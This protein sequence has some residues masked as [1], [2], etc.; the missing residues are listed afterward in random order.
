[1]VPPTETR[2]FSGLRAAHTH[3]RIARLAL[4]LLLLMT[5]AAASRPAGTAPEL[6]LMDIVAGDYLLAESVS[7]Y[8]SDDRWFV[9]FS[10][11]LSAV[12]FPIRRSERTWTGWFRRE[13]NRFEWNM[14]EADAHSFLENPDGTFVAVDLLS[15]WFGVELTADPRSQ[16]IV[17]TSDEPLPFQQ[18]LA[19]EAAKRRH[20]PAEHDDFDVAIPDQYRWAT[21]PL[22]DVASSYR[23]Q[24]SDGTKSSSSQTSL[25][26]GMDL[27]KHSVRYS[28]SSGDG[29]EQSRLT[30]ERRALVDGDRIG[31]G[32]DQ[33]AFGDVVETGANLVNSGG[34]GKGFIIERQPSS[35]AGAQGRVTITGEG[36]PGWDV[37]LYRNESLITFGTVEPD[38]RFVF[39]DQ[40]TVYGE[41]IFL[42]KLFGPQGEVREQRQ[43]LWGG[44]IQLEPGDYSFHVSRIDFTEDFLDGEREGI[45]SLPAEETT[46]LHLARAVAK[47]LQLGAGY[48]QARVAS[49]DRDGTFS[50]SDYVTLD[51][52]MNIAEG[53]LLGELVDQRQRGSAWSLTW[54]TGF[55]GNNVALSHQ[56]FDDFESPYT[57]GRADLD[58]LS[59][60][61]LSGPLEIAGLH[62]YTL[63]LS[64]QQRSDG[65]VDLRV[66]NR[67]GAQWG[68]INVANDLDV[69]RVGNGDQLVQGS[70]RLTGRWNRLSLRGQLDYDPTIA[71]LLNQVS[72]TLS[73]NAARD[74]YY[75]LSAHRNMRNDRL[76][77]VENT[78]TARVGRVD[79]SFSLQTSSDDFWAVGL[80]VGTSFGADE[81]RSSFAGLAHTG[82]ATLN[83]F[84]DSNNN[85]VR[86]PGEA[87][88]PWA[89][90]GE[91]PAPESA[92]GR[93]RLEAVPSNLPIQIDSSDFRF[94]DPFLVARDESYEL[95]THPGSDVTAN[96]PVINTADVEG[97]LYPVPGRESSVRG[98]SVV[99]Y[100]AAGN[101]VA[102]TRSEFDGY[103]SF[104]GIPVGDYE[105]VVNASANRA[106]VHN[107]WFSLE[108]T[109]G[110]IS[111]AP[112]FIYWN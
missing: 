66:F 61:T 82:R 76:L 46:T 8:R 6:Y 69:L 37:E 57:V 111:L 31:L 107:Q 74:L 14:D 103:Y 21:V 58:A 11:F 56:A 75:A 63:R 71:P 17:L 40:E 51:G 47:E 3:G 68:P 90:Y 36:P 83:F 16:V 99:L 85:G 2:D 28:G 89:S 12:E 13:S 62:A 33:Y 106:E 110:F 44:G 59:E 10:S 73:W 104:H 80:T 18:R 91:Q 101:P 102:S 79:L 30:I 15:D 26:M 108:A 92:S 25:T 39:P 88:V 48:T 97:H 93:V 29:G 7:T 19:R 112:M 34:R 32:I 72:A 95:Y 87:P 1:M 78:L 5:T 70:L 54:L 22:V 100:D 20:R 9:H 23:V 65:A 81:T 50:D 84:I 67:L 38:G 60:L 41:N 96:I 98:L 45:A 52:R 43:N 42:V 109:D 86:D 55:R 77:Y 53:L 4:P 94:N 35:N 64:R 24:E 49:S 105:L 27:L